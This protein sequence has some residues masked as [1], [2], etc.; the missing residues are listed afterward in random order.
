MYD[1]DMLRQ[2]FWSMSVTLMLAA[3]AMAQPQGKVPPRNGWIGAVF[4]I[5]LATCVIVASLISSRRGHQD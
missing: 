2:A 4:A 3:S 1:A 5:A